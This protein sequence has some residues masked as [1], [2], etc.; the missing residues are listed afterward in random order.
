[1]T[2]ASWRE[3][4]AP[5]VER[6]ER[7]NPLPNFSRLFRTTLR[8]WRDDSPDNYP[9]DRIRDIRCPTLV[10][11]GDLD[12]LVSVQAACRIRD[13]V[14]DARLGVIPSG[15]HVVHQAHPEWVSPF[16]GHFLSQTRLA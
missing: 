14:H 16:I 4:F 1:L 12:H 5:G 13:R 10:L 6:Y 2:E 3:R 7:V 15:D 9:G 11:S 8:M